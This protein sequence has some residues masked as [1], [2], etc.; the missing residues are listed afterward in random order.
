MMPMALPKNL[1]I[2]HLPAQQVRGVQVLAAVMALV[3]IRAHQLV[4]SGYSQTEPAPRRNV[5]APGHPL[6]L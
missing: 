6:I 1:N 3:V 5:P 4:L 2:S